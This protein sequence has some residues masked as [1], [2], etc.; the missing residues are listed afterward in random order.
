MQRKIGES[1]TYHG[2]KMITFLY[3]HPNILAN[4]Q[5]PTHRCY[6][7]SF[8]SQGETEYS[9]NCTFSKSIRGECF[10]ELAFLTAKDFRKSTREQRSLISTNPN[11]F[12]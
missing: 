3:K 1:F 6:I 8:G 11:K 5:D 9:A 12:K 10:E 2:T 7:C 4:R